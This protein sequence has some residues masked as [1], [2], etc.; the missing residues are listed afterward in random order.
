MRAAVI[1]DH[2]GPYHRA[3]LQAAARR[4]E[5]KAIEL[6]GASADYPW[7]RPTD[8]EA[9]FEAAT[10]FEKS[11]S[12]QVSLRRLASALESALTKT[13]PEAVLIPGWSSP[14]A[15]SALRWCWRQVGA[16]D[17]TCRRW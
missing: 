17:R 7:A 6:A 15:L 13:R 8:N 5:L 4:V 1:F 12:S 11:V 14:A 9:T 2:L 3:R 10:L 16:G